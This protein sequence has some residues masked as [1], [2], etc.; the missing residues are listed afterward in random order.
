VP[1]TIDP[2][3]IKDL[4]TLDI[5]LGQGRR[6]LAYTGV[7]NVLVQAI[8]QPGTEA[9]ESY[10]ILLDVPAGLLVANAIASVTPATFY[11]QPGGLY[12]DVRGVQTTRD[13]Q[14]GKIQVSFDGSVRLP[15]GQAVPGAQVVL[16]GVQFM[17]LAYATKQP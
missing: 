17:A 11:G 7:A 2:Q 8:G 16:S 6:L 4:D 1:T 5:D 15:Y 13:D 12:M 3:L 9:S 14:T 10:R